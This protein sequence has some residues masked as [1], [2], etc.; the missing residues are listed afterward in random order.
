MSFEK[1]A[2]KDIYASMVA[3]TRRRIPQLSDF[4][5]GSVIRSLYESLSYEMALL[6]EQLDLVYQAGFVDTAEAAHL[7]RVIAVLGLKRN[8]PDFAKGVVTFER[9]PGS[10]EEVVIPIGT[11][12]VTEEDERQD[13]S[14]KAYLTTEE[15]RL[16]VGEEAAEV[17]IQAEERGKK[18][19]TA[20]ETIVVM[21]RPVPGI[22]R[23]VN[24]KSIAFLGRDRE[25]D[26]Q[27]RERAKKALLA[28]GRASA[29]SIE[30]ALWGMP[31]VRDVRQRENFV[32]YQVTAKCLENLEQDKHKGISAIPKKKAVEAIKG[33][34]GREYT[35]K[36]EF[37]HD[38]KTRLGDD[39][40]GN[41]NLKA[42]IE[43]HAYNQDYLGPGV[44][45]VYVDGL[46]NEN[47]ASMQARID[48][49]RAAGVY[50]ILKPAVAVMLEAVFKI[51]AD[52]RISPEE[53]EALEERTRNAVEDFIHRLRMGQ[54]LIFSQLTGEVLNIKGVNDLV[55]FEI[56]TFRET[57][58]FA[59]GNI[60]LTRATQSAKEIS[61]PVGTL[62]RTA[63]GQEF[64]IR[65]D[66]ARV[67]EKQKTADVQVRAVTAGR[68]G[69][70][71]RTGA[72]VT[73]DRLKPPRQAI[74]AVSN[75]EPILLKRT[76]YLPENKRIDVK[77]LERFVCD[78]IRVASRQKPLN[79]HLQLRLSA[80]VQ[81]RQKARDDIKGKV[82]HF[83]SQLKVGQSFVKNALEEKLKQLDIGELEL[84]ISTFPFQ[85]EAQ[86]DA[87][88]IKVGF[89]E[90]PE[91][92]IIFV[93]TDRVELSGKLAL[94]LSLSATAEEKRRVTAAVRQ[95]IED[96]L[97]ALK[98]EED[99][100]L[101]KVRELAQAHESVLRVDFQPEACALEKMIRE[102]REPL[103]GRYKDGSM[104]IEPFEKVFLSRDKFEMTV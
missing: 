25:T 26:E 72:A 81:D 44:I 52:A 36:L 66:G 19:T 86:R 2:F 57:A 50:V 95:S 70:L 61:I 93:Y 77:I 3:D 67:P 33:L 87:F 83:F 51:D 65:T 14:K 79:V 27:L 97:E 49:V 60:T 104:A 48:D 18:M 42:L 23:V 43:K 8:E 71:S 85:S 74:L 64:I 15:G 100:D 58:S 41:E 80:R 32:R 28:S 102:T 68:A 12:V 29:T 84:K 98:P 56:E 63:T 7:D 94:A 9:D 91:P 103:H 92:E 59:E 78:R 35:S 45:E 62:V 90:K 69:E 99:V 4:E 20:A 96:Y 89:V 75:R 38:L 82:E 39:L 22:K 6:Y 54:P 1:K 53:S 88:K 11:L 17:K 37:E 13:P 34:K 5:P 16:A 31:G 76:A 55:Q 46:T 24:K 30:N 21:P 47:A 101:K 40:F 10:E 73:W